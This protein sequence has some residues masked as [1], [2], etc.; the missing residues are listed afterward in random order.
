MVVFEIRIAEREKRNANI[1]FRNDFKKGACW[2]FPYVQFF[3]HTL[4]FYKMCFSEAVIC[5]Q[6]DMYS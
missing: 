4:F 2:F 3:I 5:K 1:E 6:I